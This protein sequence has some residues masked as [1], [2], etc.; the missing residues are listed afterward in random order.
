MTALLE[1]LALPVVALC[2]QVAATGIMRAA[3]RIVATLIEFDFM[4][5]AFL[6]S[7]A[8]S[9]PV[10]VSVAKRQRAAQPRGCCLNFRSSPRP[11]RTTAH[12]TWPRLSPAVV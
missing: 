4:L 3:T 1:P 2:W 11:W 6:N 5:I 7:S 10:L 9:W 8:I 12:D